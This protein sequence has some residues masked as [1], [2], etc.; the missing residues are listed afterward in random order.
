MET[1][2]DL[3]LYGAWDNKLVGCHVHLFVSL[4]FE[5]HPVLSGE[6]GPMS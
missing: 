5:Q 4:H 6:L 3:C 2:E 1:I